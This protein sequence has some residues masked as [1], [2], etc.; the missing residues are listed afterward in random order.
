MHALLASQSLPPSL[1]RE[2]SINVVGQQQVGAL[3]E[4]ALGDWVDFWFV[5]TPKPFVIYADH[6]EYTTFFA[7]SKSNLN[8]VVEP[9]VKQGFKTVEYERSL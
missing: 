5:P 7:N 2:S 9:L 3:L 8:G 4:A 6:D 1:Q